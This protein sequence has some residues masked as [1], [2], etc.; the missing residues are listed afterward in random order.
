MKE[1]VFCYFRVNCSRKVRIFWLAVLSSCSISLL[2][3]CQ[4]I[5]ERGDMVSLTIIVD[6]KHFSFYFYQFCFKH[7]EAF[8][9][10]STYLG[11][12]YL[13]DEQTYFCKCL[14]SLSVPGEFLCSSVYLYVYYSSSCFPLIW[15]YMLVYV[16]Y[17]SL[18]L[19]TFSLPIL[20]NLKWVSY[21]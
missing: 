14:I 11:L 13:L 3:L 9:L 21:R 7:F 18:C 10:V 8:W 15:V 5:S 16:W 12:L 17:N 1:Y 19:F 6:L 2:I 20:L 4:V